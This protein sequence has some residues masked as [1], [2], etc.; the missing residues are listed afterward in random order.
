MN[1]QKKKIIIGEIEYWRRTHLLPGK[2]CDFLLNLYTEG[3]S[4]GR[5]TGDEK[6][7]NQIAA[8]S[9]SPS[10][11]AFSLP[12]I[13]ISWVL[14]AL[15]IAV[16]L[17]LAFHF[18]DFT[19][20]MQMTL[21]GFFTLL[22]YLMAFLTRRQP[23]SNHLCLGIASLLLAVGGM[24]I[25]KLLG[26]GSAI[27]VF[28]LA[29]CCLVW[30][31]SGIISGKRYIS[32]CGLLGLLG[33]YGWITQMELATLFS[34][35]R[36]EA[37]WLPVSIVLI[38]FG[39]IWKRRQEQMSGMLFF[40]GMVALFG[41]EAVAMLTDSADKNILLYLI[42]VKLFIALFLLLSLKNFWWGWVS[43]QPLSS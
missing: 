3:E 35:W 20:T 17:Y 41:S 16:L 2:Y 31:I 26:Y 13:R 30:F 23:F 9:G 33:I 24:H 14:S 39:L 21:I 7:Q 40:A 5:H 10:L 18:T 12:N 6:S 43:K 38:A 25:L 27:V 32:F 37:F 1:E 8:S 29:G 15:P 22:F 36:I 42:Y 4:A 19:L 28:F 11:P 34:W